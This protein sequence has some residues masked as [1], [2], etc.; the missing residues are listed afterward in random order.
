MFGDLRYWMI[1]AGLSLAACGGADRHGDWHDTI[2]RPDQFALLPCNVDRAIPCTLVVAGG[3]RILFGAPAGAGQGMR[4]EDLRQLDAVMIFSLRAQE[5]EGLDEVRNLS[6]QAGR[7]E[8]LLVIGPPGLEEM[9]DALNKAFEQ[10]DALYVVEHGHPA[11]GYDAAILTARSA[12]R[13][14]RVFDTGDLRVDRIPSG[15]RIIYG[16]EQLA[17]LYDCHHAPDANA[18]AAE[19]E[20]TI[21]LTCAEGAGGQSW[22]IKAPIFVE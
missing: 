16:A 7:P 22:P 4:T 8:P 6:W 18:D 21:R 1:A 5:V 12:A 15:F 3:K 19:T 17:E 10:A 14:Q 20:P 11:G 2:V 13:G 9:V